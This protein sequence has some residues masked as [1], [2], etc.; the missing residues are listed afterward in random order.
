MTF[1]RLRRLLLARPTDLPA[2]LSNAVENLGGRGLELARGLADLADQ[3]AGG[4][5]LLDAG[6]VFA[7][8]LGEA[9]LRARAGEG[10]PARTTG[11]S[12]RSG[13][14]RVARS[15]C[16]PGYCRPGRRRLARRQEEMLTPRTLADLPRP[17]PRA[18]RRSGRTD[19]QSVLR[20]ECGLA[21]GGIAGELSR[22]RRPIR[23]TADP[24]R[25][26]QSEQ[27]TPFLGA[28]PAHQSWP[29]GT[30]SA[31]YAGPIPRR[32]FRLPKEP[33]HEVSGLNLSAYFVRGS[34]RLTSCVEFDN[35]MAFTLADSFRIRLLTPER[36]PL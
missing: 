21:A 25:C 34:A 35:I 31:G 8:R 33:R 12:A 6:A 16:P 18:A 10:P 1:P 4:D 30:C 24:T 19:W 32:I 20:R 2:A 29:T 9:R 14:L 13:D 26:R 11:S 15:G 36:S 7:W 3:V 23:S 17:D 22:L 27:S 5:E 28:V